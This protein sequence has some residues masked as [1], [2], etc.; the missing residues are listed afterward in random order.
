MLPVPTI[1]FKTLVLACLIGMPVLTFSI[2][3]GEDNQLSKAESKKG[4]KLL[5]DGKTTK[6]WHNYNKKG[7]SE[8]WKVENNALCL[9]EK[10]GGDI[11]SDAEYENFELEFDW[12][13]SEAGNSGVFYLVKEDTAYNSVWKT[14]VEYQVLDN[15]KHSDNKLI[16]H[17][18][19]SNYDLIQPSKV[20][21]KP[22]GEWNAAKIIVNKG[23]VEHWLNGTKVVEY[24][25]WSD[26][27]KELVAKS[28]FKSLPGY[29]K[30]H[31]GHLALQDHGDKV[32]YKNLKIRELK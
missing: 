6:G 30:F 8:K 28:K 25:L 24:E 21:T 3:P 11:V 15:E 10:G 9:S 16:T 20:V 23:K 17:T 7:I 32:W 19:G 31:K 27:W 26:A 4:F 5:F 1:K 13:I 29:A 22:V 2:S 18:A 12:K 14:G